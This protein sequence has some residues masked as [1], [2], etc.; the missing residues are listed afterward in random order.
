MPWVAR[1]T[2]LPLLGRLSEALYP[3][4]ARN[5]YRLPGAIEWLFGIALNRA[6]RV[7]VQ[8]LRCNGECRLPGD[9]DERST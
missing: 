3:V 6:A 9:S 4:I 8:R 7:Q 2:S 1:L 5:R